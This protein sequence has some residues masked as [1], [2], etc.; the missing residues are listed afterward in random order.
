MDNSTLLVILIIILI[1]VISNRL[2]RKEKIVDKFSSGNLASSNQENLIRDTINDLVNRRFT[3]LR[4]NEASSIDES[5]DDI[6]T[7]QLDLDAPLGMISYFYGDPNPQNETYWVEC[8]GETIIR[9]IYPDF[10][11]FYDEI[12]GS[13]NPDFTLPNIVGRTIVGAGQIVSPNLSTNSSEIYGSD[14]PF[15]HNQS[16]VIFTSGQ[17]GGYDV[18]PPNYVKTLTSAGPDEPNPISVCENLSN[19]PPHIYLTAWIK[20]KNKKF[21]ILF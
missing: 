19:M 4:I 9:Q 21:K 5:N 10:F 14:K 8:N 17:T 15:H 3:N 6:S 1:F 12:T 2:L 7:F 13:T 18:C 11:E 16:N 20:V